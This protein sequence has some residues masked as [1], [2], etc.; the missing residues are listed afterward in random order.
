MTAVKNG[1]GLLRQAELE[2]VFKQ[3]V[4][5]QNIMEDIN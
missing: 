4:N 5:F 3:A 2:A 1:Y